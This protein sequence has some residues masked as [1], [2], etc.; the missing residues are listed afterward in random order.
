MIKKN[1]LFVL[2]LALCFSC[3]KQITSSLSS[4]S[5]STLLG[6]E[7]L[8]N[9]FVRSDNYTVSY[10]LTNN[11]TVIVGSAKYTKEGVYTV[12]TYDEYVEEV[13]YAENEEGIFN[14]TI[15]DDNTVKATSVLFGDEKGNALHNLFTNHYVPSL[16][17]VD[18]ESMDLADVKPTDFIVLL[19]IC[20]IDYSKYSISSFSLEQE[21]TN[22]V[23]RFGIHNLGYLTVTLS[24]LNNTII[25]DLKEYIAIGGSYDKTSEKINS[26]MSSYNYKCYLYDNKD[27]LYAIEYYHPDYYYT[28]YAS[29]SIPNS[30]FV[31]I[32]SG[33]QNVV[34]GI[35]AINGN[36]DNLSLGD[37]V[38]IKTNDLRKE[39]TFPTDLG[40]IQNFSSLEYSKA[41]DAYVS[42]DSS[43]AL[44]ICQAFGLEEYVNE[45]YPYASAVRFIEDD[46]NINDSKVSIWYIFQNTSNGEIGIYEKTFTEF[47]SVNLSFITDFVNQL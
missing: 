13:G 17:M 34:S 39:F 24:D 31:G 45:L 32:P 27:E 7:E 25:A 38:T 28:E 43:M 41:N 47:N 10:E 16:N 1:L 46:T 11:S 9:A 8:I 6:K 29:S 18:L 21:Q 19:S 2:S 3:N 23:Y 26:L 36:K 44:E 30:G 14:F 12:Y 37:M 40:I 5:Q 4:V 20:G 42:D 33:H 15:L 35:Y 22:L